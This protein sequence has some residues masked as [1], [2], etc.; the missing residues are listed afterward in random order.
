VAH[1]KSC[2]R[3][4]LFMKAKGAYGRDVIAGVC[5]HVQS[6]RL[7]WDFLLY[8]DFRCRIDGIQSW[9]GDGAIVDFDDP[10]F[11]E[12]FTHTKL[13]VVAVGGSYERDADYPAGTPYVATDNFSLV[14]SAYHH[15]VDMGLRR[16][17]LYS[18]PA[19]PTNRWAQ[20]RERAYR[21]LCRR[22][23]LAPIVFQGL[24]TDGLDWEII[25]A[26]L[27]AWLTALPKP[28][29]VIAVTDARARQVLQAC[30]TAG[31]A[32]PE[33]VALVGIDDDTLL[34]ML[35]RIPLSSV[36]QGTREMG[37][38]AAAMLHR[39]LIGDTLD[40][41]RVL[42]PPGGVN[43]QLSSRHQ[44]TYDPYVMRARHYIRQFAAQGAKVAQVA[45]YVGVSR[46]T[47]DN[48]FRKAFGSTVHDDMLAFRLQLARQA[49]ERQDGSCE[50]IA[51]R[52]GFNTVQYMHAVFKRELGM[53]PREYQRRMLPLAAAQ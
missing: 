13:P 18:M 25:L 2:F 49:L 20:E 14:A 38:V 29:G 32:V 42:V 9:S 31:I 52:T 39:R 15:L 24:A 5:D 7:V 35:A 26:D 36:R 27:V 47:L 11:E 45:D 33:E 6:T 3:V 51:L 12:A 44:P 30:V 41:P 8:E 34:R 10:E 46:A 19:K 16:F 40:E 21:K 37:R 43:A 48:H 28:I 17:A 1:R 4:A 22:D 50:E 23:S 53:S